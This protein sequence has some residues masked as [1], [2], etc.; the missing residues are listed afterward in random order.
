MAE[1][2]LIVEAGVPVAGV[3]KTT[4]CTFTIKGEE[5]NEG[6]LLVILFPPIRLL[7]LRWILAIFE[8]SMK[9]CPRHDFRHLGVDQQY[10]KVCI[11]AYRSSTSFLTICREAFLQLRITATMSTKRAVYRTLYSLFP[12][13]DAAR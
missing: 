6:I 1:H 9:A 3:Q 4:I 2:V 12:S 7:L 11:H 5:E 8:P 13:E 10:P